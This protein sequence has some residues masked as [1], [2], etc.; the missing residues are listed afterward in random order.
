MINNPVSGCSF[1]ELKVRHANVTDI[2]AIPA[3][4]SKLY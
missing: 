4:L 3:L 1:S 2:R